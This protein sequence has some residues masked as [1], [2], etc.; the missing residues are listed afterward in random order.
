MTVAPSHAAM[1]YHLF[2]DRLSLEAVADG[3]GRRAL[4]GADKALRRRAKCNPKA[5]HYN[6]TFRR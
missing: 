5:L 4:A 6:I 1:R 3:V 2:R